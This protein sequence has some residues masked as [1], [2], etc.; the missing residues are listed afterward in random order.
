MAKEEDISS[1]CSNGGCIDG[2]GGDGGGG[3]RGSD[4]KE[5]TVLSAVQ[6]WH[7]RMPP[8]FASKTSQRAFTFLQ[9]TQDCT[10]D[11]FGG[12][13]LPDVDEADIVVENQEWIVRR[14]FSACFGQPASADLQSYRSS[15][16]DSRCSIVISAKATLV[17]RV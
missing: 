12:F 15:S 17:H 4:S 16:P 11:F 6:R 13:P 14:M 8:G 1:D 7:L 2:G 10:L 9:V 5:Q 3:K